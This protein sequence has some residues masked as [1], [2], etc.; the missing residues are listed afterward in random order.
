MMGAQQPAAP[1]GAA[2]G[3][4]FL[5]LFNFLA[6]SENNNMTAPVTPPVASPANIASALIRSMLGMNTANAQ[7]NP[8]ADAAPE[9]KDKRNPA[10]APDPLALLPL[11][12]AKPVPATRTAD[13]LRSA[14]RLK[15]VPDPLALLPIATATPVPAALTADPLRSADP[16]KS[17]LGATTALLP[18]VAPKSDG[19]VNTPTPQPQATVLPALDQTALL[20]PLAFSACLTKTSG[21][22]DAPQAVPSAL[23]PVAPT[24]VSAKGDPAITNSVMSD[25]ATGEQA[26]GDQSQGNPTLPALP[27]AKADPGKR[28]RDQTPSQTP[29]DVNV[30]NVPAGAAVPMASFATV[31][32]HAAL[33][34]TRE[35]EAAAPQAL[36]EA[37]RAS[38]PVQAA[39]A[40][41]TPSTHEII[42]RVSQ[43]QSS[44]V[45]LQVT[46]RGGEVHVAVRTADPALQSSLRQ[47]LPTL[48]NSL[49]HAGYHAETFTPQSMGAQATIA[50]AVAASSESAF[51]NQHQDSQSDSSNANWPGASDGRQQEQR[52]RE[53]QRQNWL[54]EMEKNYQ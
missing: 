33:P 5:N 49:E 51:N 21:T 16:V 29:A 15:S 19:S 32:D 22:S 53:Q 38:E 28:E 1:A 13:P 9:I 47:D 14:D 43:P 17:L 45:D 27:I 6:P 8:A 37:L 30:A 52:Q 20:S 35:A 2:E 12:T 41:S 7:A 34:V 10:N 40:P 25:A 39:P 48:V 31:A 36:G 24:V 46:Q 42:V 26:G 44:P 18:N 23:R 3:T 4:A 50:Q 11:A 54:N